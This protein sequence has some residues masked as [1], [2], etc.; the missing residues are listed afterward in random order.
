MAW[1]GWP[2]LQRGWRSLATRQLNMFTLIAIG[3]GAA[4][5]YSAAATLAPSLFPAAMRD[6]DG[7][8]PVFFEAASVITVLVLLGQILEGGPEAEDDAMEA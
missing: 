4:W 1:V 8:V 7:G 5:I 6:G 3:T 2:F